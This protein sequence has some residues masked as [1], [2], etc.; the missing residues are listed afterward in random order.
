MLALLLVGS[1]KP[2]NWPGDMSVSSRV[3]VAV[4]VGRLLS[5]EKRTE[6]LGQELSVLN[7]ARGGC[8]AWESI[9]IVE[10]HPL[11]LPCQGLQF[12]SRV[13]R[14]GEGEGG[15]TAGE[16]SGAAWRMP[17]RSRAVSHHRTGSDREAYLGSEAWLEWKHGDSLGIVQL[18]IKQCKSAPYSIQD[19]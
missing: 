5:C 11:D 7:Y 18:R 6:E 10:G 13:G 14:G 2:A 8:P 3:T 4:V 1:V 19:I 15:R 16:D 17:C 12:A 9:L